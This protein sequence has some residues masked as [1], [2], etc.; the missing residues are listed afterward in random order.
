MREK[1]LNYGYLWL[2]M[3]KISYDYALELFERGTKDSDNVYLLYEDNTENL[4]E[5]IDDIKCH[6]E[7][8]G[9]FGIE[10]KD[11]DLVGREEY[12]FYCPKCG[13]ETD[14]IKL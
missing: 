2:G 11:Y 12:V 10:L 7:N 8:G 1:L 9:E 14:I 5:S 6:Y 4:A 3:K 13:T